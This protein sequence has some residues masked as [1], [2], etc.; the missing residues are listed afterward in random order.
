[1]SLWLIKSGLRDIAIKDG[2]DTRE[3]H[4]H[5]FM[6]PGRAEVDDYL[7]VVSEVIRF[8][9]PLKRRIVWTSKWRGRAFAE[10]E[11]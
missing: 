8:P 1:V 11:G 5:P 10:G 7:E 3:N 6:S 9:S 2:E 4:F